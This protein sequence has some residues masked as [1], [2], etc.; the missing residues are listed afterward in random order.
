MTHKHTNT[1]KTTHKH[2]H[3]LSYKKGAQAHKY[4]HTQICTLS[5]T[6]KHTHTITQLHTHNCTNT[7]TQIAHRSA[8]ADSTRRGG[9]II[10][11]TRY[12]TFMYYY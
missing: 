5:H 4:T 7:H 2:T 6:H 9:T 8:W 11:S 10:G 3:T 1:I 12:V